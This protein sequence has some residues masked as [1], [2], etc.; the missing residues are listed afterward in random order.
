MDQKTLRAIRERCA[1]ATHGARQW[2]QRPMHRALFRGSPPQLV[3]AVF[4]GDDYDLFYHALEDLEALLAYVDDLR[5]TE[6]LEQSGRLDAEA[7]V[8]RLRKLLRMAL[9]YLDH[10]G[11]C[12]TEVLGG[13]VCNCGLG[14]LRAEIGRALLEVQ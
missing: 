3:A 14:G 4:T 10:E 6:A 8:E 11:G 2:Q 13:A 5:A 9:P 7:E 12:D 1:A